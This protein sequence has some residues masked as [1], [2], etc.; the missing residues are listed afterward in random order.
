MP[1]SAAALSQAG[2]NQYGGAAVGPERFS[3]N[4]SPLGQYRAHDVGGAEPFNIG[5]LMGRD[6]LGAIPSLL[7]GSANYAAG[8]T[9]YGT[10]G[11]TAELGLNLEMG[12]LKS[13][14]QVAGN[15]P[16]LGAYAQKQFEGLEEAVYGP[17]QRARGRLSPTF[18]RMAM[19]GI[20]V[21]DKEIDEA[22]RFAIPMER[23]GVYMKQRMDRIGAAVNAENALS[24][25]LSQIGM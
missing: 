6:A 19:A 24:S 20:S 7:A 5:N 13:L 12:M 23:R 15:I 9:P 21:S 18:E 14:S 4:T 1:G 16:G 10:T 17:E 3:L 25:A 22:F 2:A 11:T 8:K